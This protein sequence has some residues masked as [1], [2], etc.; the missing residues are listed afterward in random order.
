MKIFLDDSRSAPD[1]SWVTCRT[2]DHAIFLLNNPNVEPVQLISLDN[3]LGNETGYDLVAWLEA[4]V[5]G[6]LRSVPKILVHSA[7]AAARQRIEQA[8]QEIDRKRRAYR[9]PSNLPL[10]P[11]LRSDRSAT[12]QPRRS[13]TSMKTTIGVVREIAAEEQRVALAP[14]TVKKLK[15][16]GLEVLVERGA[17]AGAFYSDEDYRS[18]G[19]RTVSSDELYA[20]AELLVRLSEPSPEEVGRMREETVLLSPLAPMSNR[21]LVDELSRRRVTALA[22]DMLPRITMAQAMDVLSSQAN[23][24]GY[25]AVVAASARLP[26]YLP[27]L[28]TAAGTITPA[29][30]LV[31][32]TGVA[33]LQ[34]IGTAKRLG[35]VVE[36]TDARPE[37]K[38][39]VESLGAKFL[40]VKGV[41]LRQGAGGYAAEQSEEY[42]N[43]QA[44]LIA[45][46]I[47]RADIVITTALIPGR[48]APVLVTK[49]H[50][51][52]MKAGSVIVD[53]AARA[54][55]NVE[56][57]EPGQETR[58]PNGVLILAPKNPASALS[59]HA[60]LTFSRN[61]EKLILHFARDGA[62]IMSPDD[63]IQKGCLILRAGELVHPRLKEPS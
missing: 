49:E 60:S 47:Q 7:D 2:V 30:V 31:M 22:L 56:C 17:G 25:W 46:S 15:A 43:R 3:D 52:S 4:Q 50:V 41:E 54:G 51:A 5:T 20:G 63:D 9:A 1:P 27:M 14:E 34:A 61:L 6:G 24:A 48:K 58:T 18:A 55:G 19:A 42:K 45:E 44:A 10:P 11:E 33:G 35:A 39:Q 26:K 16:K 59:Q 53:L 28:M 21:S 13:T 40:E 57:S 23:I 36:A 37:T 12:E 29:R 8:V 62:W 32:G 38:E